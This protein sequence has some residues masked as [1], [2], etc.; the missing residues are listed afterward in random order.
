MDEYEII[1]SKNMEK[2]KKIIDEIKISKICGDY[3]YKANLIG[4][5]ATDLLMDNF[6]IDFHVYSNNFSVNNIYTLIGEIAENK[7]I[8]STSCY[9]F[10]N[11]DDKSLDWHIHYINEYNE[12]W[13]IDIIF[14]KNESPYCGK[15]ELLAE[16]IKSKI[17][18][19]ERKNILKLKWEG[20]EIEYKGIEIYKA[21]ME[22]KIKT[23]DEFIK[24]K[25]S[26][27]YK[28]INL[29]EINI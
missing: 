27:E 28:S 13:K 5:V 16:K 3:G 17:T 24:W 9:N 12:N 11:D 4:S 19:V 23:I 10:L 7:K 25:N 2:A 21:V 15:A 29:W 14:L 20:K 6:D 1:A 18:D 8:V 22:Y 26:K